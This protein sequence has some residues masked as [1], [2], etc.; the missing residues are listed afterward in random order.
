MKIKSILILLIILFLSFAV[1]A[2]NLKVALVSDIGGFDDHSYNDQLKESLELA[3][4]NHNLTFEFKESEL[5]SEYLNNIISFTEADFDLI[6]GVSFTMKEAI[7]EAAQM[8]PGIQFVIF[9]AVVQEK[10]VKSITFNNIEAGFLAGITAALESNSKVVAFIGGEDNKEI[11]DYKKGFNRGVETVDPNIKVY[12][13]YLG[14]FNDFSKAKNISEELIKKKTDIIFYAAGAASKGI[15][16]TAVE[17]DIRLITLDRS[18][19][20][21]AP[22]N[23]LTSISKNTDKIVDKLIS[24]YNNQDSNQIK[25]YGISE[26]AFILDKKQSDKLISEENLTKIREYKKQFISGEI[27]ISSQP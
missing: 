10:N 21:L 3:E 20:I 18:D 19:I 24:N 7:K 8:Y 12:N 23:I 27:N 22:N 26:N 14:S 9:D 4:K 17:K 5:M 11:S 16:T 15:I 2:Q 6:W 1:S 13:N 25:E